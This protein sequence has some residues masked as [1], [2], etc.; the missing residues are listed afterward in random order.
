MVK[1]WEQNWTEASSRPQILYL[2]IL[3]YPVGFHWPMTPPK[4][5]IMDLEMLKRQMLKRQTNMCLTVHVWCFLKRRISLICDLRSKRRNGEHLKLCM[6]VAS[7]QFSCMDV[8]MKTLQQT[9]SRRFISVVWTK[10]TRINLRQMVAW[11]T[12]SHE[13][14]FETHLSIVHQCMQ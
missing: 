8:F 14:E 3:N 2:T 4:F 5:I 12:P 9:Q 13:A 10:E 1:C 6:Y 7:S 11:N